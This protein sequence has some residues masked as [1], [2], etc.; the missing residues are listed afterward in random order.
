ML[1]E[2][3]TGRR[4][5]DALFVGG[6]SLRRWVDEAFPVELVRVVDGQLLLPQG[7][8][9]SRSSGDGFFVRVFEV[10][11]LCSSE[12]P[13]QRM[14]MSEVAV[15]LEK[16]KNDYVKWTAEMLNLSDQNA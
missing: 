5:T 8:P 7:S 14:T 15:S 16:I 4:P 9:S 10:G 1:L 11:L 6:L 3:F 12:S 13:D 2:V